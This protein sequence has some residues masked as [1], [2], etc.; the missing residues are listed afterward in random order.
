MHVAHHV[1]VERLGLPVGEMCGTPVRHPHREVKT[2]TTSE[3]SMLVV[4]I[5][6]PGSL[7]AQEARGRYIEIS[8][9]GIGPQSVTGVCDI[10]PMCVSGPSIYS[11]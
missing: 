1:T 3:I 6:M 10:E 5:S 7:K 11:A 4:Y 9:C 8:V 2:P